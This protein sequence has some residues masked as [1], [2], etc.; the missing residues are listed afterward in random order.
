M[1]KDKHPYTKKVPAKPRNGH[2]PHQLTLYLCPETDNEC[3]TSEHIACLK[4]LP[5][6]M[7][8]KTVP[9]ISQS[10]C[11]SRVKMVAAADLAS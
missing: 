4:D 2:S 5:A 1:A 9:A 11:I 8:E 7:K 3:S 6:A 10:R